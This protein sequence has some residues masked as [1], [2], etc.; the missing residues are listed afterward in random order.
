[1]VE[2]IIEDSLSEFFHHH[3]LKYRESWKHPIHFTGSVAYEFRDVIK[4]IC[5]Q[6]ELTLG[7]IERSPLKG[8]IEF[9]K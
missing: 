4:E 3:I 5:L 1:M 9:H 2:N 8:L 7:K 6:N